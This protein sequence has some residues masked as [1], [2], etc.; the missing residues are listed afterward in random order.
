MTELFRCSFVMLPFRLGILLRFPLFPFVLVIPISSSNVDCLRRACSLCNTSRP[1]PPRFSS[2][3]MILLVLL[4]FFP[5]IAVLLL[6]SSRTHQ[7]V[8]TSESDEVAQS[9]SIKNIFELSN[10]ILLSF[11]ILIVHN[12]WIQERKKSRMPYG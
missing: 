3:W 7:S 5:C 8:P 9:S 6:P 1:L 11:L 12:N 10:G 2:L 4:L